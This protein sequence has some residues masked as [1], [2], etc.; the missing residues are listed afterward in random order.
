[1]GDT[2]PMVF[3]FT[4]VILV[5][6]AFA[7]SASIPVIRITT[8]NNQEPIATT[9]SAFLCPNGQPPA[10]G[11]QCPG[12]GFP[13]M[14]TTTSRSY[15]HITNFQLT[16]PNNPQN[17]V[18]RST[19]T[20]SIRV[21][22]NSTQTQNKRPYRIR[23]GG[24]QSLF[25]KEA[26]RSWVLLA[27]FFDYTFALNAIA[28]ELG[29]RLGLAFTPTYQF[30][31]VYINGSYKGIYQLT[32]QVQV[33]RG[34]VD[35]DP[36][37]GW[38][39][40]FDYHA[41]EGNQII[42]NTAGG[43]LSMPCRIRD[44]E[45]SSNFTIDNPALRFVVD[46]VN[47]LF[48]A[49]AAP[50]FPENGYRDLIDLESWAKYVLI[51]QLIDNF[52]FNSK[53]QG[54][55]MGG[56]GNQFGQPGSNYA[57]KDF[58][59]RIHAGPLWDF[60]LAA[61]VVDPGMNFSI[62]PR[63]Y[64]T[65]TEPIRPRHPFYQ[66]LWDDPV[67]LAKLKKAW[68]RHQSDFNAIPGIIDS[69]ANVLAPRVQANFAAYTGGPPEIAPRPS[70]EQTY[71]VH[72][73]N[74]KNWWSQRMQFFGQELDRM[75]IDITRD[76]DQNAGASVIGAHPARRGKNIT[77]V[78]NGFRMNA[79]NGAA[80]KIIGLNGSVVRTQK[81]SG[82]NHTVTLNN[83]PKGVYMV[84]ITIDNEKRSLRVPVW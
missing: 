27:N 82:G 35:I 37:F 15:I 21:R 56:G 18:T 42:F 69:I 57:Y 49:M 78:K 76:I 58:G 39:V 72:V 63:H 47:A 26:A 64:V 12:G 8:H 77:P 84:N 70:N 5:C 62:W 2:K 68:D 80:I 16:D 24:R 61:G 34:R 52:D 40:E 19:Q 60:D 79:V 25:G 3:K 44:P 71:M 14:V 1:M 65:H 22:G 48:S 6:A 67:F 20:D 31:D 38:L 45:V 23:F 43:N 81:F 46:Q 36:D 83:L 73:N 4:F 9:T 7:V 30:A 13:S 33:N 51:Q 29:H 55:G 59:K 53:V 10:G 28:F 11:F 75:N 17:N 32:E 54:Q 74:L 66:R 50:G 41:A